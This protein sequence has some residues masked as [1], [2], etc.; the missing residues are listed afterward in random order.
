MDFKIIF[1]RP[2]VSNVALDKS[3]NI[4]YRIEL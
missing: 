3:Q 1:Q 2:F 4:K